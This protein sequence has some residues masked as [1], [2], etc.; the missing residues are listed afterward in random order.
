[1][2]RKWAEKYPKYIK[3]YYRMN[4]T[5]ENPRCGHWPIHYRFVLQNPETGEKRE[6]GGDCFVTW[7]WY[8][9]RPVPLEAKKYIRGKVAVLGREKGEL[10]EEELDKEIEDYARTH[11]EREF[12]RSI[13][14]IEGA[15]DL[16]TRVRKVFG[17]FIDINKITLRSTA[18]KPPWSKDSDKLLEIV[19][20][21]KRLVGT[22]ERFWYK[23]RGFGYFDRV[24]EQLGEKTFLSFYEELSILPHFMVLTYIIGQQVDD[25]IEYQGRPWRKSMM[26]SLDEVLWTTCGERYGRKQLIQTSENKIAKVITDYEEFECPAPEDIRKYSLNIV[27]RVLFGRCAK[28]GKQT[29]YRISSEKHLCT[30]C[31]SKYLSKAHRLVLMQ[32]SKCGKTQWMKADE[33][34]SLTFCE[35]DG[36]LLRPRSARFHILLSPER[37]RNNF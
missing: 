12:E 9:H 27:K 3:H 29:R 10:S 4:G 28:C 32:C 18:N 25:M 21:M 24:R 33:V 14:E 17:L 19:E 7:C 6:V 15:E 2:T 1:M 8:H 26:S 11:Y 5:C 16:S 34:R 35:R 22:K 23:A 20:R 31:A 30:S 13:G 37:K 36:T